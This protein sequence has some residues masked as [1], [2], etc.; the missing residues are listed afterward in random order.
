MPLTGGLRCALWTNRPESVTAFRKLTEVI[1]T[2]D[3]KQHRP[4][5]SENG[6]FD[7][8]TKRQAEANA[9]PS[10]PDCSR[11]TFMLKVAA[12]NHRFR[13]RVGK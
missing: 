7:A 5:T 2:S 10:V 3:K 4:E 11:G 13:P 12:A 1:A 8:P 9:S 6:F